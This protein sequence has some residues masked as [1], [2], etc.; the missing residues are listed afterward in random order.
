MT[1]AQRRIAVAALQAVLDALLASGVDASSQDGAT[2]RQLCGALSADAVDQVQAGTFGPPLL[3]C[4]RAA[5]TAGATFAGMDRVRQEAQ[6]VTAID[7]PVQRVAQTAAVFALA[8][9]T[10]ILA[11]AAFT[12][13]QDIDAALARVNAAFIPAEDFAAGRFNTAVWRSI[14]AMHGAAVRDL[15]TRARPLPRIVPYTFATR[16]PLLTLSNRL[17]GD[18]GRADELLAENRD[19]VHPLFM[20]ASGRA[21]SA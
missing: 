17:F 9:M 8:Q 14:L 6:A 4:Y 16:M 19:T 12:S 18:A 3:A 1:F 15:N 21:L 11:A 7:L 5:T 20:P 10:R 13:R 2:L